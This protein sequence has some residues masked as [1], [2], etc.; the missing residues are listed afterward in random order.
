MK[1]LAIIPARGGSKRIPRKN[2][3]PFMGKPIIA[4]SIEAAL[5]SGIFDEVMVSTD[6][7]EIAEV[8]KQYGANVPFM[9]SKRA[10]DDYATTSDVI[11]EVLYNYEKLGKCMIRFAVYMRQPHLSL[12]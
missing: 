1:N 2:I 10:A 6:D 3:K 8:A 12:Q 4:Y 11:K 7:E 5:Q 9:R